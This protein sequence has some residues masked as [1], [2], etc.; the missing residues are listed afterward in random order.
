LEI[1][2][3][4][5]GRRIHSC[6]CNFLR[7]TN[8]L[9]LETERAP[10]TRCFIDVDALIIVDDD[11]ADFDLC[12]DDDDGVEENES[13]LL[14]FGISGIGLVYLASLGLSLISDC[15]DEFARACS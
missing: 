2:K 1:N 10:G 5:L 9:Q 3:S 12:N 6:S 15:S 4:V 7:S 13:E 8:L 11:D 14:M